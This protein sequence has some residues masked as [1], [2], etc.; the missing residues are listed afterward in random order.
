MLKSNEPFFSVTVSNQ[1][2]FIQT[3]ELVFFDLSS[4][5]SL[6]FVMAL[7]WMISLICTTSCSSVLP[8]ADHERVSHI[9]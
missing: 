5:V 2:H 6:T 1:E 8:G 9:R 7:F 3:T 4:T